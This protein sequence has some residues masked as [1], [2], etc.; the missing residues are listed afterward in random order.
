L[1]GVSIWVYKGD[2]NKKYGNINFDEKLAGR[3]HGAME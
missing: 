1:H 2:V 3:H